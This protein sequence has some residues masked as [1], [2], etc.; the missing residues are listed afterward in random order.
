MRSFLTFLSLF[1]LFFFLAPVLCLSAPLPEEEVPLP[2]LPSQITRKGEICS[3][4]I[5]PTTPGAAADGGYHYKK[6]QDK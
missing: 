1:T 3:G 5:F 4:A 6:L 2:N